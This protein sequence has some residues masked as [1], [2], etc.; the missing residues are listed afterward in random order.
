MPYLITFFEVTKN[1]IIQKSMRIGYQTYALQLEWVYI[2]R[3][4]V[5]YAILSQLHLLD[6]QAAVEIRLP[7]HRPRTLSVM[8][9]PACMNK[10][11]FPSV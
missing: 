6:R 11:A 8:Q 2:C 7:A 10:Q 3:T 1:G 9:F 4:I 5:R